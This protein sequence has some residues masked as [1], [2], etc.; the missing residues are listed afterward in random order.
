MVT[1]RILA[2]HLFMASKCLKELFF[3]NSHPEVLGRPPV[4]TAAC[5]LALVT[6]DVPTYPATKPPS[7]RP[8]GGA[9]GGRAHGP[10]ECGDSA[11]YAR[12]EIAASD[13]R[14]NTPR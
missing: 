11:H 12:P 9:G 10:Q 2:L 6:K 4:I 5:F 7:Q 1:V 14:S 3:Y 8:R 13:P